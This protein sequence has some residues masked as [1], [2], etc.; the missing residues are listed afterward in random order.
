MTGREALF[1]GV[2]KNKESGS[3]HRPFI[4]SVCPRGSATHLH[5]GGNTKAGRGE[6]GIREE[7][8]KFQVCPDRGWWSKSCGGEGMTRSRCYM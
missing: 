1:K 2:E 3:K 8:G 4:H 6:G 5:F 7:K